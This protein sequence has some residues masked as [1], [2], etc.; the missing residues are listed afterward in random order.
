MSS[1]TTKKSNSLKKYPDDTRTPVITIPI[2]F[3][4][5][6]NTI[7]HETANHFL[8]STHSDRRPDSMDFLKQTFFNSREF[9]RLCSS[10]GPVEAI[11]SLNISDAPKQVAKMNLIRNIKS[12]YKLPLKNLT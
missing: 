4:S 1:I 2:S 12:K 7:Y 3:L 6:Q 9:S 8:L 5:P 10:R 11:K